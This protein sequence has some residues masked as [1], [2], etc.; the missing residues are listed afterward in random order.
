MIMIVKLNIG[1][2]VLNFFIMLK[3]F[4]F[5]V[6]KFENK[7]IWYIKD[8]IFLNVGIIVFYIC[9]LVYFFLFIV[10]IYIIYLFCK[11]KIFFF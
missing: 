1:W 6:I 8:L 3:I 5:V 2:Y 11:I 10:F 9:S 4:E 7:Y